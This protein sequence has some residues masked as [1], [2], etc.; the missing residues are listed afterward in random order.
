M[1][2]KKT[3]KVR[4]RKQLD[5]D[6]RLQDRLFK[7]ESHIRYKGTLYSLIDRLYL[8]VDSLT[9]LEGILCSELSGLDT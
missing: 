7:L 1:A 8:T 2:K 9:R 6:E 3:V 4:L 5:W